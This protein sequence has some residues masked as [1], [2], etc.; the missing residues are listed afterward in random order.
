MGVNDVG[1]QLEVAIAENIRLEAQIAKGETIVK[2]A[3]DLAAVTPMS[4]QEA[5]EAPT[6]TTDV[7]RLLAEAKAEVE[8]LRTTAAEDLR[9][10]R[11]LEAENARL[12]KALEAVAALHQAEMFNDCVE[13]GDA[14]PCKTQRVVAWAEESHDG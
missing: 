8:N 9:M 6:Y 12:R 13:D 7:W 3:A 1:E 2:R 10:V 14:W 11:K 5:T 4:V